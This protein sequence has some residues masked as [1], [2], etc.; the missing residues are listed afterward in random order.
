MTGSH[1][2]N[3]RSVRQ[4]FSD[5]NHN[6]FTDLCVFGDRFYL[7]FRSCPDGH[8]VSPTSR[9]VVLCLSLLIATRCT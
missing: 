6:A 3:V 5:G 7:T 8:G 2:L 4:V 1:Q 9:I